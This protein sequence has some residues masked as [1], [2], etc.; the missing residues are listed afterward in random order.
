MI[1]VMISCIRSA[2]EGNSKYYHCHPD[3]IYQFDNANPGHFPDNVK[4]KYW[5][6]IGFE[7]SCI[8]HSPPSDKLE[9]HGLWELESGAYLGF[10]FTNDVLPRFMGVLSYTKEEVLHTFHPEVYMKYMNE[11]F[12]YTPPISPII[13]NPP[14]ILTDTILHPCDI[15]IVPHAIHEEDSVYIH[16]DYNTNDNVSSLH[17]SIPCPIQTTPHLSSSAFSSPRPHFQEPLMQTPIYVTK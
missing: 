5:T 4:T 17:I 14:P 16:D 8:K 7:G 1:D 10:K 9:I 2:K 11:T 6:H 13:T 15:T 3:Y 12:T